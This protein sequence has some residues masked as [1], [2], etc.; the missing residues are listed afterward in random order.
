M[1]VCESC[2]QEK[3]KSQLYRLGVTTPVVCRA[4]HHKAQMS[5]LEREIEAIHVSS[6]QF[7][8]L[9]RESQLRALAFL[10]TRYG[11]ITQ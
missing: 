1:I 6:K 10:N 3:A 9:P 7:E 2:G 5:G 11:A 4:C 8:M